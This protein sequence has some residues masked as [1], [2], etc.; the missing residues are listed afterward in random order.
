[1]GSYSLP[2]PFVVK[3]RRCS[4]C[5]G[6]AEAIDRSCCFLQQATL[7]FRTHFKAINTFIIRHKSFGKAGRI[8]SEG[9]KYTLIG[10]RTVK[11]EG[12]PKLPHAMKLPAVRLWR[13]GYQSG[14]R[15]S[16]TRL[17]SNELRRVAM[18]FIPV[19]PL[20][21]GQGIQAKANKGLFLII[22]QGPL[23]RECRDILS[24]KISHGSFQ[25][26]V[27]NLICLD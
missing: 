20:K 4:R 18:P 17:R 2:F 22:H 16:L 27:F 10:Y 6:D 7:S 12:V 14:I 5:N 19:V 11:L 13:T 9:K 1:M 8:N 15:H 3:N 24:N 21:A 23:W 25:P 26:I